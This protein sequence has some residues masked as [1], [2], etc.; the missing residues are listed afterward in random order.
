MTTEWLDTDVGEMVDIK[1]IVSYHFELG[2]RSSELSVAD[3]WHITL[4]VTLTTGKEYDVTDL[5][6]LVKFARSLDGENSSFRNSSAGTFVYYVA[7]A[8]EHDQMTKE[9]TKFNG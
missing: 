7:N 3:I 2:E 8:K 6:E 9:A 4:T 5:K 1:R